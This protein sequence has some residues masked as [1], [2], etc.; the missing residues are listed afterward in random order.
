MSGTLDDR[1]MEAVR[2]FRRLH[3]QDASYPRSL[4]MDTLAIDL[5]AEESEMVGAVNRLGKLGWLEAVT[6]PGLGVY[7]TATD[8]GMEAPDAH[9]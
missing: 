5:H 7:L 9:P 3:E 1:V 6:V 8:R 4:P 2:L